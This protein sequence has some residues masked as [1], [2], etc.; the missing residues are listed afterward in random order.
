[1]ASYGA[2]VDSIRG[3]K[4]LRDRFE[5]EHGVTPDA[6]PLQKIP[7]GLPIH[8]WTG[9]TPGDDSPSAEVKVQR[10]SRRFLKRD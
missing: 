3:A 6:E 5:E 7:D 2:D 4:I 9:T 1:L 10:R 8:T